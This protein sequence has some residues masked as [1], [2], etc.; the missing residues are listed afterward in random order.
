[1]KDY[2]DIYKYGYGDR[3]CVATAKRDEIDGRYYMPENK[4]IVNYSLESTKNLFFV[5]CII[6]S[7][8]IGYIL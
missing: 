5:L 3:Y 2:I 7:F 1:M 8:L 4:Y 6:F